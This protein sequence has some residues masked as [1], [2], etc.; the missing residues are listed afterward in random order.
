MVV[1]AIKILLAV[2]I[3]YA[4]AKITIVFPDPTSPTIIRLE[5]IS[6]IKSFCISSIVFTCSSVS[7]N[8]KLLAQVL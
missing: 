7:T 6:F 5:A 4:D 2:P 1:G 8:G 3:I